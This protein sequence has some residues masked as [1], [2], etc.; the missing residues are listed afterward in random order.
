MRETTPDPRELKREADL[1]QLLLAIAE[2]QEEIRTRQAALDAL[3]ESAVGK[4]APGST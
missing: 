4:A 2:H 3:L 1:R